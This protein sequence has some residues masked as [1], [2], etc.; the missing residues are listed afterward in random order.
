MSK[1]EA[2]QENLDN[3]QSNLNGKSNK[4]STQP[5]SASKYTDKQIQEFIYVYMLD[6]LNGDH[7]IARE[8]AEG[9]C[10]ALIENYTDHC[11]GW[12][13]DILFVVFGYAEAHLVLGI[14]K[15]EGGF[16]VEEKHNEYLVGLLDER[17]SSFEQLVPIP[18]RS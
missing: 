8:H 2:Q 5:R 17:P 14:V 13:G 11:P 1:K 15:S 18:P 4:R 10:Y 3:G 9:A 6:C 12:Y 7:E 16:L